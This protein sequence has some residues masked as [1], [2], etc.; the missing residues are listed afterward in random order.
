MPQ[1]LTVVH[2]PIGGAASGTPEVSAAVSEAARVA[3]AGD[4]VRDSYA[5]A[6]AGML[7]LVLLHGAGEG[8]AGAHRAAWDA[9]EAGTDAAR[10][11]GG[12]GLGDG[13]PVDAF[14]GSL[15]GTG[16]SVAEVVLTERPSGPVV[17]LLASGVSLGVLNLP[18]ARAFA[19]P[20]TTARLVE[21]PSLRRGFIFEVHDLDEPRKRMFA[22]P[23][24][25]HDLLA[26]L[27]ESD[28]YLLRSIVSAEGGV[29]AVAS[30]SRRAEVI[31]GARDDA[32]V[33]I[34]R[35]GGDAPLVEELLA[36]FATPQI[37]VG[38]DGALTSLLPAGIEDDVSPGMPSVVALG[39]HLAGQRLLPPADLF[40]GAA[41]EGTRRKARNVASLLRAQG[42]F[43]PRTV[44]G[45]EGASGSAGDAER[46]SER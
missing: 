39:F 38:A 44:R 22:A 31:P 33:A 30:S 16:I 20:F 12:A 5:V 8:D 40:A 3:L 6:H 37:M 28:R 11:L 9:L 15:R 19:D 43:A 23:A 26:V 18:L 35:T 13:L 36:A 1:T 46:W 29:T 2:A 14:T 34:V 45:D 24:E 42:T 21:S 17:V 4:V 27:A 25:L 10:A 41:F 7:S 32:P